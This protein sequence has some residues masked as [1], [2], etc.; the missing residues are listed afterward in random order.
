M[1]NLHVRRGPSGP[2]RKLYPHTGDIMK[3]K[4]APLKGE[5]GQGLVEYAMILLLVAAA[6]VAG[7]TAFGSQVAALYTTVVN[8]W[9]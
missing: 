7:L 3:N 6:T 5:Q 4:A 8:V 2:R 9:P 1:I